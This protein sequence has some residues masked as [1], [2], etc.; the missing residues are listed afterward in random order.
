MRDWKKFAA[1]F[2]G[3][4][5]S[6]ER[7]ESLYHCGA[8]LSSFS[9]DSYGGLGVCLMSQGARYDLRHGR[10]R[11]GWEG[12]L[13][14]ARCRR[15]TKRTKCTMCE[16]RSMCGMCPVNGGLENGDEEEPVDY[17]CR[18]AH[19]RAYAMDLPLGEH[20]P[21]EYCKGGAE[22]ESLIRRA[23]ELKHDNVSLHQPLVKEL[24]R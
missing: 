23:E 17:L 24:H 19:L 4:V 3:P 12:F 20:G 8:G 16:I 10:F 22:Y 14:K 21:C 7:M 9:I 5:R 18:V 6:E 1:Q 15:I 2:N 11:V 13:E